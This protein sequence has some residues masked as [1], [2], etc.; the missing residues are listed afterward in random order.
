[1]NKLIFAITTL[2]ISHIQVDAQTITIQPYLQDVTPQSIN[3]LWETDANAESIVEW[4]QTTELGNTTLGISYPSS[5]G[6]NIHEVQLQTLKQFTKYYYIVRTGKMVSSIYHFKTAPFSSDHESFKI[7]AMSDMQKDSKLPD[8][9]R[10]IV[11]DGVI[12]YLDE[13]YGGDLTDNLALIM[14]PGDLVPNGNNFEEWK[15]DFFNPAEKLLSHIPVYPVLGNH[16][17]NASYYFTYFKLPDNGTPG[18]E[19][20]WWYKDYGNLRIIGL[21]SNDDY[22]NEEQ[23]TWLDQVLTNTCQLDS[24]DFL[25]VQLHH[26]FK[27]ELWTPGNEDYTG[28]V[29]KKLE[30]FSTNCGKPSIH[31]FGHTH[32]YSRGHSRDHKHLMIN[33]ASAGGSLDNWGEFPN[34]DYEEYAISQDEYGFV[35]VEV[36]DNENPTLVIKRIGRGD[37]DRIVDNELRD[38]LVLRLNPAKVNTPRSIFPIEN[39]VVPECVTLY[40]DEFSAPDPNTTHGQS[41]WQISDSMDGFENPIAES[42]K[43]F[44]NWYD[45][46]NT[47]ANDKLTDESISVELE[48]YMIYYWRVR[49]RDRELNWSDWSLPSKFTTSGS[50]LTPNLL[51]N[52]GAENNL[53]H[54]KVTE[55][56]VETLKSEVCDGISPYNGDQYFVVGG[57][58]EHSKVGRLI[59]NVDVSFKSPS[60]NAGLVSA[61]FGGYLSDF[62][63]SDQ[64]QMKLIFLDKTG[65]ILGES[66]SIFT[67]NNI[68]TKVNNWSIIPKQTKTIQIELKGT[69]DGASDNDSYFDDLFLKIGDGCLGCDQIKSIN[70]KRPVFPSLEVMPISNKSQVVLSIPEEIK[71]HLNILMEDY[72]SQKYRPILQRNDNKITIETGHLSPKVYIIWVRQGKK[73]IGKANIVIK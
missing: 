69:R 15:N 38:S 18:F 31:F 50:P 35:I 40:A 19:E 1:M 63:G 67:F 56:I 48:Q 7:L 16:E 60:I 57:L 29:I 66:S 62:A 9:F 73:I 61:N 22:Q 39:A 27:S 58:C 46:V 47:Q 11:E 21:D 23:L 8:K 65:A 68:W 10:E 3:I 64:P 13:K 49:Y 24:I 42:W 32:A 72:S 4:G 55:G 45:E 59:Q 41:H 2:L 53:E 12:D 6:K 5:A 51:L 26:P 25:F 14:I 30:Q 43:N 28:K 33:V 37:Q 36:T 70:I 52:P 17:K 71:G 44:E 34:F 54:W 20:H